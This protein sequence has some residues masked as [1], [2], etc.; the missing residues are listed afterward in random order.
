MIRLGDKVVDA[1]CGVKG[2]A[3]ARTEYLVGDA[4]VTIL[5]PS[6][7]GSPPQHYTIVEDRFI[8]VNLAELQDLK[9]E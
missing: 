8:A 7:D 2:I 4:E 6:G 3:W 9:G 1:V 5:I